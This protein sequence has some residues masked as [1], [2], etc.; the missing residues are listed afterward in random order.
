MEIFPSWNR[1]FVFLFAL[2]RFAVGK[3]QADIQGA[4]PIVGVAAVR[5]PS[6]EDIGKRKFLSRLFPHFGLIFKIKAEDIPNVY[7]AGTNRLLTFL[8][9]WHRNPQE[10]DFVEWEEGISLMLLVPK[11]YVFI[12]MFL[13]LCILTFFIRLVPEKPVATEVA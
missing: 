9:P 7:L 6:D 8:L 2:S 13:S 11:T 12:S 10:W 4:Y 1:V 5:F 3:L